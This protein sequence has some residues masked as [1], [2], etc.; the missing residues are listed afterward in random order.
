MRILFYNDCA[1]SKRKKALSWKIEMLLLLKQVLLVLL[2]MSCLQSLRLLLA[3]WRILLPLYLMPS[4][5]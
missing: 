5:T 3:Y 1:Q 2:Q 4:I